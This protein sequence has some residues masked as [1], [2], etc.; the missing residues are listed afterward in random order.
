MPLSVG[1]FVIG[2]DTPI[3]GQHI[4]LAAQ[5]LSDEWYKLFSDTEFIVL[6][7]TFQ[8]QGIFKHPFIQ[9]RLM[10]LVLVLIED[11]N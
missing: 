6:N 4:I 5:A 2:Y 7:S 8:K 9:S 11:W 10:V 1:F 3:S